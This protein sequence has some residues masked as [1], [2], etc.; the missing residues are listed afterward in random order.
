MD[1]LNARRSKKEEGFT[2]RIKD[3]LKNKDKKIE[4][5]KR[6]LNEEKKQNGRLEV[7]LKEKDREKS[8]FQIENIRLKKLVNE[9]KKHKKAFSSKQKSFGNSMDP[10]LLDELS[11]LRQELHS[12]RQQIYE[13]DSELRYLRD[14]ASKQRDENLGLRQ[15]VA[16]L[17]NMNETFS[18]NESKHIKFSEPAKVSEGPDDGASGEMQEEIKCIKEFL[19][20]VF[21]VLFSRY[22]KEM[23]QVVD[24]DELFREHFRELNFKYYKIFLE[25]INGQ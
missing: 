13:N 5:L 1:Y 20:N 8:E 3:D 12:A 22:G 18:L 14:L 15:E 19:L 2:A 17:E 6:K 4:L 21:Y 11:S 24:K 23:G 25:V 10:S 7:S 16:K 9:H